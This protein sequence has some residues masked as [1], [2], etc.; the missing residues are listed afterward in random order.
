MPRNQYPEEIKEHVNARGMTVWHVRDSKG[1]G[2]QRKQLNRDFA[3][4][5]LAVEAIETFRGVARFGIRL[6][7]CLT[8]FGQYAEDWIARERD[9]TDYAPTTLD[10]YA[11]AF[12]TT[13]GVRAGKG[14]DLS[15]IPLAAITYKDLERC[16][17]ERGKHVCPGTLNIAVAAVKTLFKYA[18]RVD[19]V[20]VNP[21]E[22]LTVRVPYAE[23]EALSEEET[24]RFYAR[25]AGH[26]H[27]TILCLMLESMLRVGEAVA[28]R[29]PDFDPAAGTLRVSRTAQQVNGGQVIAAHTKSR[30][31]RSVDLLECTVA[32]LERHRAQQQAAGHY[33]PFGPIFPGR[34]ATGH[35]GTRA[36]MKAFAQ[37]GLTLTGTHTLRRTGAT[38]ALE[39]GWDQKSVADTLGH[40]DGQ[41]VGRYTLPRPAHK[42]AQL[43]QLE[44]KLRGGRVPEVGVGDD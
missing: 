1:T 9:G 20:G 13:F 19:D 38:V 44:A 35:L 18:R 26:T 8:P 16:I 12:T 17:H 3:T 27:E 23:H 43:V 14:C 39:A 40:R 22:L 31:N 32:R 42:R 6:D 37:L 21:A 10:N 33:Q 15:R 36:V 7:W 28:L 30:R 29:W 41:S 25:V 5:A 2:K 4:Y 34:T 11:R 24:A